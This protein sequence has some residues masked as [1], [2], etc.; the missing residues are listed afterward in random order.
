MINLQSKRPHA[1]LAILAAVFVL[2]A[3]VVEATPSPIATA[4]PTTAEPSAPVPTSTS[5]PSSTADAEAICPPIDT[6]V[7]STMRELE[8]QVAQ[9]RGLQPIREVG[10]AL[11]T[12]E[13]L[14]ER[15]EQ[16]FLGEYSADEARRDTLLLSLLGLVEPGTDLHTLYVDLLSEQVAGFYDSEED[17]MLVVCGS[18]FGGLEVFTY[19]HEY[20]HALQDQTYDLEAGLNFSE[21][22]CELDGERCFALRALIEGDASLLQEQW[23][24]NYADAEILE[25]LLSSLGDLDSPVLDSAPDYIQAELTFPYLAGLSFV[26]TL[27]LEGDWAAVDTAFLNPP[28][29][30]EQI[31]HPERYPRDN[32]LKLNP[33]SNLTMLEDAWE[34]TIQDTLGEWATLQVLLSH[35]AD[36]G[37][38]QGADG[39]GGDLVFLL[40]DSSGEKTALVLIT[41][42]DT[43]RDAHEF[44]AAF[45]EYAGQRFGEPVHRDLVEATWTLNGGVSHF[46]RQSNQTR[47]IIAPDGDSLSAFQSAF[48]LPLTVVP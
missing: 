13:Q 20:V 25:S 17:E 39:W 46:Q 37:A 10:R 21:E 33:P 42:W 9:L 45:L 23:L 28:L 6:T 24:R 26:R 48:N 3:C 7:R 2:G 22:A 29:S 40:E 44:S 36:E 18:G 19:V 11:L 5:E 14:R 31:M 41:Q 30:T 8:E 27:Y 32:P 43:M 4:E 1:S 12:S 16:D 35:L 15:V 34:I 47:W 38:R